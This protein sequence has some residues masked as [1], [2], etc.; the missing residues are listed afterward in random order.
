[1]SVH[2]PVTFQAKHSLCLKSTAK[3]T[4]T[5]FLQDVLIYLPEIK[6]KGNG[7]RLSI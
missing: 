5:L 4:S 2:A 7:D 6:E 3:V 1:M